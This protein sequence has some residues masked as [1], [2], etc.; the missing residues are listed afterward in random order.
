VTISSSGGVD[1]NDTARVT[2]ATPDGNASNNQA[3]G[4]VSFAA[5]ADLTIAKT[6]PASVP[7]DGTFV[8]T[9]SVDNAG[10]STASNVVVTDVLPAGVEFVSAV[11][12]VGTFTVVSNVVTWNLGTV[13]VADPVRTLQITVHVLPTA[14]ATLINTA[15]VTSSTAD[16]NSANNLVTTTTTVVGTDLWISKAGVVSAGNPSG[17]LVYTITVHN[18]PGFVA[19]STPTSGTGG[20]NAAANVV[21]VD[22]LPLDNKKLIVQFLSPNCTYNPGAHQV[23][24]TAATLPAGTNVTFEI[25]VQIK[26]SV[27]NIVNVATVT[28]TTPDPNLANNTDTVNNVVKGGTGKQ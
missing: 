28:S 26:G 18:T 10:P 8:Y 1:V 2:S 25:Q 24:C 22:T 20:P 6:A 14:P 12:S 9:V 21:V 19:D 16:P 27:G 23:T 13:A 11:A 7:L 5:S 4:G 15:S 3:T 17:A